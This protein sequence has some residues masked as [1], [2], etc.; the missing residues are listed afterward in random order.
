MPP[1]SLEAVRGLLCD[2]KGYLRP[3]Y[4]QNISESVSTGFPSIFIDIPTIK[5]ILLIQQRY[6]QCLQAQVQENLLSSCH[7]VFTGFIV[8]LEDE[9]QDVGSGAKQQGAGSRGVWEQSSWGL[10]EHDNRGGR[11]WVSAPEGLRP[12]PERAVPGK[13]GPA[14]PN[15]CRRWKH[16]KSLVTLFP[17]SATLIL[18]GTTSFVTALEGKLWPT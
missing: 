2:F 18:S 8:T 13:G 12:G 11:S 6:E 16:C 15:L 1:A 14:V 5:V 17:G 10:G 7:I 9:S 4:P 3:W